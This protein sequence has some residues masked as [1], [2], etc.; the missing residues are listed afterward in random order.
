MGSSAVFAGSETPKTNFGADVGS[1]LCVGL[2]AF[3]FG[4]SQAKHLAAEASF[5]TIQ[6]SQDHFDAE[7]AFCFA[8][9][10]PNPLVV[11]AVVTGA[12]LATGS[13]LVGSIGVGFGGAE[14]NPINDVAGVAAGF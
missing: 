7:A 4:V 3:G 12:V 1:E 13:T 6:M 11:G 8:I 10:S 9:K 2:G 14:P 5:D